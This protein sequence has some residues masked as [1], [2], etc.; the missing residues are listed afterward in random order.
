MESGYMTLEFDI[1]GLEEYASTIEEL[2]L[3]L[4]S[5]KYNL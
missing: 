2:E 1:S 3:K 5:N 4:S